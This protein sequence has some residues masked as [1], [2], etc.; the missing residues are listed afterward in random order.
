MPAR[1]GR[2]YAENAFRVLGLPP[3]ASDLEVRRRAKELRLRAEVDRAGTGV[4]D[5]IRFAEDELEE[6]F[7]RFTSEL[8]WFQV[9]G[10]NG[11]PVPDMANRDAVRAAGIELETQRTK[12]SDEALH[13]L[14][15]LRH[16]AALEM[17]PP[18]GAVMVSALDTWQD[19]WSNEAFWLRAKL[20]AEELSDPRLTDKAV[21]R[22]R[23][24]VPSQVLNETALWISETADLDNEA[25]SLAYKA[26]VSSR[27]P[28]AAVRGAASKAVE[29]LSS[30]VSDTNRD[31]RSKMSNVPDAQ[32]VQKVRSLWRDLQD[33]IRA[34]KQLKAMASNVP[35]AEG[36]LDEVAHFLRGLGIDL[37]NKAD[38]F[39][40]A[41]PL[42]EAAVAIA[43]SDVALDRAKQDASILKSRQRVAEAKVLVDAERWNE[44]IPI[45]QQAR[46]I[47]PN[48]KEREGV[49]DLLRLCMFRAAEKSAMA[50]AESG[51]WQEAATQAMQ[52]HRL[53]Y[54]EEQRT[55]L[56]GF[57]RQCENAHARGLPSP[58]QAA[59]QAA[60]A[61]SRRTRNGWIAAGVVVAMIVIY[62]IASNSGGSGGSHAS[63]DPGPGVSNTK[64]DSPTQ[65]EFT[66]FASQS[67][68]SL[69]SNFTF[70][71][72]SGNGV[73]SASGYKSTGGV[74]QGSRYHFTVNLSNGDTISTSAVNFHVDTS[75][76]P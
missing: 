39:D 37:Y 65:L 3:T 16:A 53:A 27:F 28:A 22:I 36:V 42:Q 58:A 6:P 46:Q 12:G 71:D 10:T 62:A 25:A 26:L 9:L 2:L 64:I 33:L 31:L 63:F 48:D 59:A 61:A 19:L 47:A 70:Y 67:C 32:L 21:D 20:R 35:A 24:D 8:Y 45:L 68:S 50:L 56:L 73:G 52:A 30:H 4:V 34:A 23:A 66:Y 51:R 69:T 76:N 41:I 29:R 54:T 13:D 18:D 72:G 17:K 1:S 57:A 5:L 60:A 15:V 44:A 49:D 14:A 7:R 55:S 40:A 74:T 11:S 38:D 75:C 43:V